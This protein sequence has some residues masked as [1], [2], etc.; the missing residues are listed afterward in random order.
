MGN[1]SEIKHDGK[2]VKI[3]KGKFLVKITSRSACRDCRARTVCSA[4]GMAEKYIET[5]SDRNFQIGDE[6]TVFMEE[7]LGLTAV[8]YSFF[9][10]FLLMGLVLFVCLTAGSSEIVAAL[11]AIGSLL[12]YYL[13]L[14]LFGRVIEKSFIFRAESR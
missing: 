10:P 3:G 14:H 2:V 1:N 8:F 6:V 12:P 5:L 4:A 13:L 9:L 11:F 7:K